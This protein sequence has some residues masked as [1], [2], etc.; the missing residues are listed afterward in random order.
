ML[1]RT[2]QSP[3]FNCFLIFFLGLIMI[4]EHYA[5]HIP[6]WL[7]IDPMVLGIPILIIIAVIPFY[8]RR[9]PE[10]KIKPSIIPMEL[11]EEDEGMQWL[12]FKA[13]RKVYIFY[14]FAIPLGIAL[15]AYL[16]HL[17]YFS[18]ILLAVMGMVQYLIYWLQMKKFQ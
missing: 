4:G 8:N 17:P 16:N 11:R 10:D 2:Y 13:T 15:T 3:L 9:N 7:V 1:K 5:A 18:I 6:S 14:A 12:T